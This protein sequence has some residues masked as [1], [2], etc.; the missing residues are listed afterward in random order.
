MYKHIITMSI[1]V[2][3]TFFPMQVFAL[4]I[5]TAPG[6]I[7]ASHWDGFNEFLGAADGTEDGVSWS[8][9]VAGGYSTFT[10]DL[11]I[12][13][14]WET[15]DDYYLSLWADWNGDLDFTADEQIVSFENQFLPYSTGNQG[16]HSFTFTDVYVPEFSIAD[17]WLRARM[18]W[19]GDSYYDND[20][21]AI[22]TVG[23]MGLL[24]G[25]NLY[26]G[27]VEDYNIGVSAIPEPA[28]V[29]LLGIGITGIAVFGSRKKGK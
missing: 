26:Y 5:G 13:Q 20:G 14:F 27:E 29:F 8:P 6:Y 4:T 7:E 25:G 21:N 2:L 12:G 9:L 10:V 22:G 19:A 18:T 11:S 28:T 1:L 3:L 16:F 15:G 24:A 23:D 17:T